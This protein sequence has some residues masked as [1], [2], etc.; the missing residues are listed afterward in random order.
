MLKLARPR[1]SIPQLQATIRAALTNGELS[2][3]YYDS[4]AACW[5][6]VSPESRRE[7]VTRFATQNGWLVKFRVVGGLGV[8]AEFQKSCDQ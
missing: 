2:R 3:I 8:V 6:H 1:G 4:L 7:A 5:P